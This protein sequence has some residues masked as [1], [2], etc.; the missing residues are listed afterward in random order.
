[1]IGPLFQGFQTPG[2]P[3]HNLVVVIAIETVVA[4]R[5]EISV[6]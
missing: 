1:M 5:I 6:I 4:Q 2:T 3:Q